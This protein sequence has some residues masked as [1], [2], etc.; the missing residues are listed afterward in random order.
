MKILLAILLGKKFVLHYPNGD[1]TYA[2]P[3]EQVK[4]LKTLYGGILEIIWKE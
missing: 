4:P 3:W 2:L 1:R